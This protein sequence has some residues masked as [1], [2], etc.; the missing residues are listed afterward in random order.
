L[1]I[2]FIFIIKLRTFAFPFYSPLPLRAVALLAHKHLVRESLACD[3]YNP[4]LPLR[5]VAL[6]SL[7]CEVLFVAFLCNTPTEGRVSPDPSGKS[8]YK[9]RAKGAQPFASLAFALRA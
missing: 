5:A 7:S 8:E 1:V 6:A 3:F 2:G 4:C 9:L